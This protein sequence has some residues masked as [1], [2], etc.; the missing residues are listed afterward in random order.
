MKQILFFLFC[1][2]LLIGCGGKSA[3][4]LKS[5]QCDKVW[6][7][8]K[9]MSKQSVCKLLSDSNFTAIDEDSIIVAYAPHPLDWGYVEWDERIEIGFNDH[10]KANKVL[11]KRSFSLESKDF[12]DCA[13]TL[14]I[15]FGKSE[16][17]AQQKAYIYEG[18]S[19]T[20]AFLRLTSPF[21]L[22]VNWR[23][24]K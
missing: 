20:Q 4:T 9:G 21:E 15:Y 24:A 3:N 14:E 1:S 6:E 19:D 13:N 7:I 16:Y 8:E 10:E 12:N 18:T 11:L 22:S 2:L 5:L 17:D 23:L